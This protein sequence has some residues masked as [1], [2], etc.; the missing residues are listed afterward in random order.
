M[1]FE[2]KTITPL[3]AKKFLETNTFNRRVKDRIVN[4]YAREMVAGRWKDGTAEPIKISKKGNV[5]DGQ[6]R[7]LAVIAANKPVRFVIAYDVDDSVFDVL[8]TGSLRSATD[9]FKVKGI[10]NDTVVPAIIAAYLS[11]SSGRARQS[12]KD[13]RPT[14]TIL[15]D[16][17]FKKEIF[18]QSVATLSQKWYISF[19]KILSPSTIGSLYA[20]FYSINQDGANSF[21][22]QLCTGFDVR[23]KTVSVL[24]NKLMQDKLS[25]FKMTQSM[26]IAI[27]LKTWNCFRK[28]D[29][30]KLLK[31]DIMKEEFPIAC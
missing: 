7:L 4:L 23:N 31:F 2:N 21:M 16:E 24:R 11:L 12:G 15:L 10:K 19:A 30:L 13:S 6:H 14:T 17:Y 27:I 5:L 29:E 25:N 22:N 1:K 8:D 9:S 20:L 28:G 26:K 3:L 18:W